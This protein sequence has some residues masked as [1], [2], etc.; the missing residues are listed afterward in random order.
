M[1]Y[2]KIMMAIVIIIIIIIILM[3]GKT[4]LNVFKYG[5]PEEEKQPFL[6][7]KTKVQSFSVKI[8]LTIQNP[9]NK[10]LSCVDENLRI[11]Y[12]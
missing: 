4:N 8:K 2:H 3:K 10:W 9:S 7:Q 11:K 1:K 12:S 6:I 5:V